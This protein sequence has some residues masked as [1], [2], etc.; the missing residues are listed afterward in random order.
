MTIERKL[1]VVQ[2][3]KTGRRWASVEIPKDGELPVVK[4]G[5][6]GAVE[7]NRLNT[8]S[9]W[10]RYDVEIGRTGYWETRQFAVN[11]EINDPKAPWAGKIRRTP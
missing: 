11:H 2:M 1:G 9:E 8:G 4:V 10:V 5:R 7:L 3:L 6:K